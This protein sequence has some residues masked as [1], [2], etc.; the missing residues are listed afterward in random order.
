MAEPTGNA[1]EALFGIL[2]RHVITGKHVSE[3]PRPYNK[4]RTIHGAPIYLTRN[5]D[6]RRISGIPIDETDQ[7]AFN[8]LINAI[9]K[10]IEDPMELPE[11]DIS[12]VDAIEFVQQTLTD[13]APIYGK[14]EYEACWRFYT[15]RGYEFLSKYSQ[16]IDDNNRKSFESA[17]R[18][19]AAI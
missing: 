5:G 11:G 15:A 14:G 16:F 7:E 6:D 2:S 10:V 4:L 12:T 8:G 17:I 13:A 19:R 3:N 1:R 9:G 18:V